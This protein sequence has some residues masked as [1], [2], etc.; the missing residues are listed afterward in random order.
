MLR[1]AASL[2]IVKSTKCPGSL[3]CGDCHGGG[4]LRASGG[5]PARSIQHGGADLHL[6]RCY[7]AQVRPAEDAPDGDRGR[8]DAYSLESWKGSDAAHPTERARHR[9]PKSQHNVGEMITGRSGDATVISSKMLQDGSMDGQATQRP[10]EQQHFQ[11]D[12]VVDQIQK[13]RAGEQSV[14]PSLHS[15]QLTFMQPCDP[16]TWRLVSLTIPLISNACNGTCR[17]RQNTTTL[18]VV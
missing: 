9:L 14:S 17:T 13:A 2:R 4:F 18:P 10:R 16:Q 12:T 15:T 5:P 11:A 1:L 8:R 7:T 3:C 6:L